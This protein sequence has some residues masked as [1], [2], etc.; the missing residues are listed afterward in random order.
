MGLPENETPHMAAISFSFTYMSNPLW[1]VSPR[2]GVVNKC[3]FGTPLNEPC[4][5]IP[6]P[7]LRC[8]LRLVSSSTHSFGGV[9]NIT[10]WS[11]S[12]LWVWGPTSPRVKWRTRSFGRSAIGITVEMQFL[13][14]L[15]NNGFGTETNPVFLSHGFGSKLGHQILGFF[16]LR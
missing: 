4:D 6:D 9:F 10:L 2:C 14:L 5:S 8:R 3:L 7:K 16:W 13:T 12:F 1:L 11:A 15:L